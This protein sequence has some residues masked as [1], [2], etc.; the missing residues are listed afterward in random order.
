MPVADRRLGPED[1]LRSTF[2]E[3]HS[4]ENVLI[5]GI[6]VKNSRFWQLHPTL[7]SNVTIDGVT[8]DSGSSQTDGCDPE[9]STDV[10]IK[11]STFIAGDDTIAIKSGRDEDGRR[12]NR[13][14]RNIVIMHC[15]F[16]GN[17][18][19]ITAGSE[20]SGGIE[21]VYGYD[22]RLVGDRLKF[23]LYMKAN[24]ARGGF[25]TDVHLDTVIASKLARTV[26]FATLEYERLHG[27][28]PPRFDDVS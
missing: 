4:C 17:W 22:L 15:R 3:P 23:I 5:Q 1:S 25:I 19:M 16:D 13:P 26:V 8:T 7:S 11:N 12:V 9:S 28:F 21:H 14:S 24:T 20:E 6:T 10:V 27:A 2:I 18:G